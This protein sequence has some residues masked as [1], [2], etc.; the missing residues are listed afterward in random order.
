MGIFNFFKEI[1]LEAQ[2]SSY[3]QQLGCPKELAN[4][5][6]NTEQIRSVSKLISNSK[7]TL[8]RNDINGLI[9]AELAIRL[10]WISGLLTTDDAKKQIGALEAQRRKYGNEISLEE[11]V[12]INFAVANLQRM[13]ADF[14]PV[15]P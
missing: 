15:L 12:S 3:L 8:P 1:K 6:L 13:V 9:L 4:K 5:T 11:R 10:I 14:I 7:K 2:A